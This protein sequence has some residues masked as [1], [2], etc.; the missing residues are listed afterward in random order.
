MQT[1]DEVL[2]HNQVAKEEWH[3]FIDYDGTKDSIEEGKFSFDVQV[4]EP[5]PHENAMHNEHS[6]WMSCSTLKP[7]VPRK[8]RKISASKRFC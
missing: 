7:N 8:K 1:K 4:S 3:D 2:I 5:D 6:T